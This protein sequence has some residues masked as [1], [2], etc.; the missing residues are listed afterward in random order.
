MLAA[1]A[2]MA[3]VEW[4]ALKVVVSSRSCSRLLFPFIERIFADGNYQG[5]EM[6]AS[7]AKIGTWKVEIV[8]RPN[9]PRFE[10]LPKC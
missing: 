3:S 7:M 6:A 9:I 1:T 2:M 5:A 8:E 4:I 10:V